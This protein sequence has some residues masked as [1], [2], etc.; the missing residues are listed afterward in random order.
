MPSV[1]RIEMTPNWPPRVSAADIA[2]SAMPKIGRSVISRQMC[3]PGS[4]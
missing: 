1:A 4:P 3:L 2:H